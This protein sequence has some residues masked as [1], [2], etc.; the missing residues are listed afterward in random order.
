[1]KNRFLLI[2]FSVIFFSGASLNCF[3]DEKA[4]PGEVD[5]DIGEGKLKGRIVTSEELPVPNAKID[6]AVRGKN[7]SVTTDRHGKFSVSLDEVA[8]NDGFNVHVSKKDFDTATRA[9][10]YKLHNLIL[11]LGDIT[12]YTAS[13]NLPEEKHIIGNVLNGFAF[14]GLPNTVV[15]VEDSLGRTVSATTDDRGYFKIKSRYFAKGSTYVLTAYRKDYSVRNDL[16]VKITSIE[17]ETDNNPQR[18]YPLFGG[19]KGV[20]YN[21]NHPDNESSTT[22]LGSASVSI[23]DSNGSTLSQTTAANGTYF[24]G[25]PSHT[26]QIDFLLGQTYY[27]KVQATDHWEQAQIPISIESTGENQAPNIYMR[28]NAKISGTVSGPPANTTM[29]SLW[30]TRAPIRELARVK[31][32]GNSFTFEDK[33]LIQG[34]EYKV[35]FSSPGYISTEAT[36]SGLVAGTNTV[37]ATLAPAP[38]PKDYITGRVGNFFP[39]PETTFVD[40][41]TVQIVRASDSSILYQST[42]SNMAQ[43]HTDLP[44]GEGSF[45][46][47]VN[48]TNG[49]NY[50]LRII[51]NGF[52]GKSKIDYQEISFTYK[53]GSGASEVPLISAAGSNYYNLLHTNS[54]LV[55]SQMALYPL[56]VFVTVGAGSNEFKKDIKQTY[57]AFLTDKIG[58]TIS[59]RRETSII[60]NRTHWTTHS[61]T[62]DASSFYIHIDDTANPIKAL[63]PKAKHTV[64]LPF[65]GESV[66]GMVQSGIDGDLRTRE[67]G[68]NSMTFFNFFVNKPVL[69]TVETMG[70]TDTVMTLYNKNGVT[71]QSDNNSGSGSNASITTSLLRGWYFA[72]VKGASNSTYGRYSIKASGVYSGTIPPTIYHLP[73]TYTCSTNAV[74]SYYQRASNQIIRSTADAQMYVAAPGE[75]GSNCEVELQRLGLV[76]DIVRGRFYGELRHIAPGAVATIPAGGTSSKGFFNII[77]TE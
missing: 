19:I 53:S 42:T 55:Q 11:D 43:I 17:N 73:K 35:K 26:S 63:P 66:M 67:W 64:T 5:S 48:L 68:L 8:R 36:T 10:I 41:A 20:V 39:N 24:F 72:G 47:N 76:G 31:T 25:P 54:G 77:R 52:T 45:R 29:V 74:L 60:Y 71:L 58:L 40:D 59:A 57:E 34:Y 7:Y 51:K 56:G 13:G 33:R 16:T 37:N 30:T 6:F 3:G 18:L 15:A 23:I 44:Q 50:L 14:E 28:V 22:G 75:D 27:L 32:T 65:N 12:I 4:I 69:V 38:P 62:E 1:M 46:I 70:S 2:L 21:D 49:E 9:A 61:Q